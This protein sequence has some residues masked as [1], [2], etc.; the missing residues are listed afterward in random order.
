M[1]VH[2]WRWLIRDKNLILDSSHGEMVKREQNFP[3]SR[4][5]RVLIWLLKLI[6]IFIVAVLV[7]SMTFIIARDIIFNH[8][9]VSQS[10]KQ[11][12]TKQTLK[13]LESSAIIEDTIWIVD[14][15][16][17]E[18]VFL[19]PLQLCGLESVAR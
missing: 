10:L 9:F 6:S 4:M 3:S 19:K 8:L 15:S 13:S 14:T 17:D 1:F 16:G 12:S 2:S 18:E 7:T 5:S 11:P